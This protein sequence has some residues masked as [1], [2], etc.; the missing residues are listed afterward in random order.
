MKPR[1]P[2]SARMTFRTLA[3]HRHPEFAKIE[4]IPHLSPSSCAFN[5][6]KTIMLQ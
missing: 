3:F 1:V 4:R 6:Q 2:E 5:T